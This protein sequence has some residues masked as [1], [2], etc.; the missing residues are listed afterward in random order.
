MA[1]WFSQITSTVT[2]IAG[3][4]GT[5]EP[6]KTVADTVQ[7]GQ[8]Y[9][10]LAEHDLD[11]TLATG[12]STENQV[13]YVSTNTGGFAFVQLIH[14]NI[15]LWNPTVSFTCRFYEPATKTNVFKNI[16][17]SAKFE[18]SADRR[19]VKTDN[20]NITLD[21]TLTTYKIQITHPDLIVSL[22]FKRVD[23]GFKVGEGKTYLGGDQGSAAGFVSHKFW[24]RA[25][26]KG[27]FIVDKAIHDVEGQGMFIHAIQGMQP[28]LI[29]SNW[30]FVNFQSK[31]ASLSMMQFTTTKQ[32]GAVEINQGSVVL[33]D[34]LIC[35]SV[36]NHV[37]LQD[38]EKDPETEYDI[39][40]K[41][42]LTWRGKTIAEEGSTEEPKDVSVVMVVD[43]KVLVDKI[44]I[45]S[46]IPWFLK[47]LVQ[48]FVV[49]PYIYQW[50]DQATAEIT[51][52]D[53]KV[54]VQGS[55]FQELVFV[56]G[57]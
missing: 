18:L 15:G 31:D 57:F 28:Q 34:K 13:F 53:E 45:L 8:Y 50:L 25:E 1:S 7:N 55:C 37:E 4:S 43:V 48:T 23:R 51:V 47:K 11:W 24:P 33:N 32:Y 41:I 2:N 56:S 35:V 42:K 16:N 3:L 38:L 49:K 40:K 29:A 52:G 19:S 44:D 20:F 26:A 12:S 30:N 21:P 36:D 14:S 6:I 27:T 10:K 39:P 54:Q 46:E 9:G 22:D 5:A 17:M